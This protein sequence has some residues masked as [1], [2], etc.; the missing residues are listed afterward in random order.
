VLYGLGSIVPRALNFLLVPLHTRGIFAPA[1]YGVY[2][3]LLAYV[4]FLNVVYTFGME[5]A[6]FR[7]ATA[8]GVDAK[9]VF[10]LVQTTVLS[11]SVL[12]SGFFI[13]FASP[14]AAGLHIGN[15]P[16]FIIW[17]A[18]IMLLDSAVAIPFARL[19]LEKRPIKFALGKII[20]VLIAIGLN[21][22]F[23][24]IN[25]DPAVGIGFVFLAGLLANV[26]YLF[27]FAN[28]FLS[29]RPAVDRNVTPA[30]LNYAYPVML[31]G[32]V[33][34]TNEMFSRLTLEWWL[35][36]NFYGTKSPA[37]ALG[38]F[39]A[40]YKYAV[41]MS[42]AI[43]AFRFAA[44]PFFFSNAADKN[45]PALFSKVNHYFVIAC[46]VL[47]LGVSI[48]MDVFKYFIGREYWEGLPIV[49]ILL[50]AY[51]FLG[52]YYNFSVWFKVT[53]KTYFG[54]IITAGGAV[55]TILLNYLLIPIAG[56]T[57]SSWAALIV[58]A[59]MAIACYALGQKYYPI[60]YRIRT[61]F[62]YVLATFLLIIFIS[63]IAVANPWLSMG[64]HLGVILLFIAVI[65]IIER[66]WVMPSFLE[67]SAP[68]Q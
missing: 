53:D 8:P 58:Y 11:I 61:D 67:Q 10:N 33:A 52:V 37:H 63:Q 35:P 40:C 4:A 22:Y 2:T 14:L 36:R 17:L 50:L 56:Y 45:S 25:Y 16:E 23:L 62:C 48:N 1:E 38:V 65:Y 42:V 64:F 20:N 27:F 41:L 46:C 15:H 29:W 24:K 32:T 31:M 51:L 30:L 49:P 34:M 66:K 18:L 43:Q 54:T 9:R 39:A 59:C 26:S 28:D 68:E 44:E 57:G 60:P 19:R 6:F 5:T 21:F 7:F 3:Y 13:A 55:L 12:L 47:W